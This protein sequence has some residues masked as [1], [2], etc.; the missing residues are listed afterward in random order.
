MFT[1][2]SLLKDIQLKVFLL[3]AYP[4][5]EPLDL[6]TLYKIVRTVNFI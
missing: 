6:I 3:H 5:V 1:Y 2:V 4:L